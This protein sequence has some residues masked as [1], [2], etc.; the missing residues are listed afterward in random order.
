MWEFMAALA[1]DAGEGVLRA[2]CATIRRISKQIIRDVQSC[3][4][5]NFND[6]K[7]TKS[8]GLRCLEGTIQNL[9]NLGLVDKENLVHLQ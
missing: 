2:H 3:I 4:V 7:A 8:Q 9:V 5:H 1:Q 6:N